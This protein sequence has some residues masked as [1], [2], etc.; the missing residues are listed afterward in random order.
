MNRTFPAKE[1]TEYGEGYTTNF[2]GAWTTGFQMGHVQK[3]QRGA[4]K[5]SRGESR[6]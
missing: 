6:K 1:C 4:G 5:W 3:L 2:A